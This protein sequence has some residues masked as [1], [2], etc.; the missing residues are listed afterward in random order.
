ME[1]YHIKIGICIVIK[2]KCILI[3]SH[4]VLHVSIILYGLKDKLS[5]N[6][7][8]DLIKNTIDNN[9]NN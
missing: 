4:S 7:K 6:V 2:H 1:L 5:W 9:S 3:R 8:A